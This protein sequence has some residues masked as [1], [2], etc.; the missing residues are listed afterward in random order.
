ML[1]KKANWHFKQIYQQPKQLVEW[2][3]MSY[4]RHTVM[5]IGVPNSTAECDDLMQIRLNVKTIFVAI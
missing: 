5:P 3:K 2:G 4:L 1:N